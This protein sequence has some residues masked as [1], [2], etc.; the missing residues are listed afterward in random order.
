MH[1][2]EKVTAI[3]PYLLILLFSRINAHLSCLFDDKMRFRSELKA[4]GFQEMT[5]IFKKYCSKSH[6]PYLFDSF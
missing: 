1:M 4:D 2:M 3:F 5:N 6:H